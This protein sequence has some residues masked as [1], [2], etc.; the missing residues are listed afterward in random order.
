MMRLYEVLWGQCKKILKNKI[1]GRLVYKSARSARVVIT[2]LKV[3]ELICMSS[4]NNSSNYY[5]YI[6]KSAQAEKRLLLTHR[7]L[8][9]EVLTADSYKESQCNYN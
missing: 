7:Q 6:I 2:L 8:N 1:R 5:C 3:I 4:G 9:K